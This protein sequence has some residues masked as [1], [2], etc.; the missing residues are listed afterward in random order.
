MTNIS[1]A[2]CR[3]FCNPRG[4]VLFLYLFSDEKGFP[5]GARRS[6]AR[7]AVRRALLL[8]RGAGIPCTSVDV[9]GCSFPLAGKNQRAPGGSQYET[10]PWL[11]PGPPRH[12]AWGRNLLLREAIGFL[13]GA[14]WS[15]FRGYA[16]CPL[17]GGRHRWAALVARVTVSL[18]GCGWCM[19]T[20]RTDKTR[21]CA[22]VHGRRSGSHL[23]RPPQEVDAR[24]RPTR[25]PSSA[26]KVSRLCRNG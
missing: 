24:A 8:M 11:P 1:I 23:H 2:H 12:L 18:S 26:G 16:C 21:P 19:W 22:T 14:A 6:F 25:P 3:D 7:G 10:A 15:G 13:V 9:G 5:A 17:A 4:G 20:D